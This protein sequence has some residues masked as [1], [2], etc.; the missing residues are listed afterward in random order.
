MVLLYLS[1]GI[2][3]F[4]HRDMYIAIMPRW[5]PFHEA[6]VMISGVAEIVFALLLVFKAT[7]RMAAWGIIIMLIAIFPANVQ[8]MINYMHEQHPRLWITIVRLPLQLLLIWWAYGFT[9]VNS[10]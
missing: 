6:M 8:M 4:V 10:Q 3:H 1:A 2:N 7:R 5:I 9:K